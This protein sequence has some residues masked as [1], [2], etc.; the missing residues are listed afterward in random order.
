MH[1]M[2]KSPRCPPTTSSSWERWTVFGKSCFRPHAAFPQTAYWVFTVPRLITYALHRDYL[3]CPSRRDAGTVCFQYLVP[4]VTVS[5][6]S[7]FY[8]ELALLHSEL[9]HQCKDHCTVDIWSIAD[10]WREIS[11]TEEG[12]RES[13]IANKC[14]CIKADGKETRPV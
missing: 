10:G 4:Q 7:T 13:Y 6:D 1:R 9:G 5:D 8:A 3:T 14:F 12:K 11:R 2:W